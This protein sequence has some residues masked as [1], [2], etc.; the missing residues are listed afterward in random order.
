MVAMIVVKSRESR[1]AEREIE[2]DRR[3][4]VIPLNFAISPTVGFDLAA[5]RIHI[6]PELNRLEGRQI[7]GTAN[8]DVL[9]AKRGVRSLY[10]ES[11]RGAAEK[12]VAEGIEKGGVR[13][14]VGGGVESR[15][16]VE[17]KIV[18]SI[19]A[20]F[21]EAVED[22][23]IRARRFERRARAEKDCAQNRARRKNLSQ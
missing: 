18:E 11:L 8:D 1:G 3:A 19:L 6:S 12:T 10:V 13:R 4:G 17:S 7:D 16:G 5:S 14:V 23:G 9:S 15:I 22:A 2:P 20:K 21:S